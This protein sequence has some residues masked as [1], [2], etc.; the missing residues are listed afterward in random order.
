MQAKQ[1]ELKINDTESDYARE[2]ADLTSTT[3]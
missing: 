1:F 3:E 2:E